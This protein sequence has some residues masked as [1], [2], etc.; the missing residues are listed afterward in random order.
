MRISPSVVIFDY[1]NVLSQSQP[2]ADT[3]A[4]A[5]ILDLPLPRFTELYWQ[6][7]IE[8][9]AA[10]SGPRRLLEHRRANR[11]PHPNARIKLAELI[12]ID[13]RSWSHPAP[14]MPQWARDLRAAG[15][16][17]ALLS[18]MPV[19]VRDYVLG[20]PWLPEFDARRF[21]LRCRRM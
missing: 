10:L 14:V 2:A 15:L 11:L 9:D 13:S 19:P 1:G 4:M 8:Y 18:N 7:R 6:F 3:Q 5:A 16:R 20:C 21:L 17:T 12:E